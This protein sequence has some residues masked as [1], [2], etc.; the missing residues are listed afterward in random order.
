MPLDGDPSF[1]VRRTLVQTY[2]HI[3]LDRCTVM[4]TFTAPVPPVSVS[5][6][7]DLGFCNRTSA[8]GFRGPCRLATIYLMAVDPCT[9]ICWMAR[10]WP[11]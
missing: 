9:P 2:T 1:A 6:V 7:P 5:S 4:L 3:H 10:F 8:S 11:N